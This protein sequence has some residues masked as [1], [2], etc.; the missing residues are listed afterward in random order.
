MGLRR[1]LYHLSPQSKAPVGFEKCVG[2]FPVLWGELYLV[3]LQICLCKQVQAVPSIPLC[4]WSQPAAAQ[5]QP[6]SYTST[7]SERYSLLAWA[8]SAFKHAG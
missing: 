1:P 8:L 5:L 6:K 3:K 2:F 4:L 7:F